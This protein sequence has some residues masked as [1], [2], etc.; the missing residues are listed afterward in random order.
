MT[1]GRHLDRG[2][3]CKPHGL[4][5][6]RQVWTATNFPLDFFVLRRLAI[7]QTPLPFRQVLFQ[8]QENSPLS[9]SV[10][11]KHVLN[12]RRSPSAH[13]A[14]VVSTLVSAGHLGQRGEAVCILMGTAWHSLL[15]CFLP[16]GFSQLSK[17]GGLPAH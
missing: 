12:E 6:G 8:L 14:G 4:V 9:A 10:L 16:S 11:Q 3:H 5:V 7:F 17:H 15:T 13:V 1:D 2:F